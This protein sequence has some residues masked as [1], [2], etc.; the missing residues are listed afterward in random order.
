[1]EEDEARGIGVM[2]VKETLRA[3]VDR[4]SD[5]EATE[6]LEYVLSLAKNG[7]AEPEDDLDALIAQQGISPVSE[8]ARLARGV[9]PEDESV[10]DFIA[11]LEVWRSEGKDG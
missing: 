9:W 11:A 3:L 5:D 1:M 6:A 7:P 2:S 10:D 8:P 4:L